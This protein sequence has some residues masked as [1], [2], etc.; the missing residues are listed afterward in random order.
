[1]IFKKIIED[2]KILIKSLWVIVILNIGNIISLII[3]IY[4]SRNLNSSDFT[5]YYSAI[6]LA[7]LLATP[8]IHQNILIQENLANL[9][10]NKEKIVYYIN[11][12][13]K[14]LLIISFFYFL[15]FIYKY[16]F[17]N[18]S[19]KLNIYLNLSFF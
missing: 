2:K 17:L 14:V 16:F 19:L 12:L 6:A 8:L 3:Q 13:I 7:N 11:Q 15:F 18:T 4:L 1:M 10:K 5:I 9:N